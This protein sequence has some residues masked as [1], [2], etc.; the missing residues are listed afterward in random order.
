MGRTEYIA[1]L[2]LGTS[3]MLSIAARKDEK[4]VLT[5]LGAEKEMSG[6]CMCR[7]YIY[8]VDEAAQKVSA[9]VERLNK[10]LEAKVKKLYVGLGGQSIHAEYYTVRRE[11]NGAFVDDRIINSLYN[12]CMNYAPELMEI[13][14]IVSPEYYLDGRLEVDPQGLPCQIIEAKFLLILGHPSLK[15]N[16]E[17]SIEE[18]AKIEIAGFFISPLATA[19]AVLTRREKKLGCALVELGAG[20][21]YLSVYKNNLLRYLVAIP[22]GSNTITRD[23]IW[24]SGIPEEEAEGLKMSEGSVLIESENEEPLYKVIEARTNEIVAN[25]IEQIKVS[26]C[27]SSM[28]EGIII[29]GGG[30]QLRN[31]DEFIRL[32][33]NK[34]VRIACVNKSLVHWTDSWSD[35]IDDPANACAF[36]LL[37]LGKENCA[38]V[39]IPVPDPPVVEP[40]IMDPSG[41][42]NRRREKKGLREMWSHFS[43]GLFDEIREEE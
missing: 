28:G 5:I 17:K 4:G 33:T 12:G 39:V 23:I 27:E 40:I 34:P 15:T 1:A 11:M 36:G 42:T 37:A 16:L 2:D 41:N 21:T 38:K 26:G 22:L 13:L 32:K 8:H 6:A 43:K 25:I 18:K 35:L 24:A 29:T 9:L 19:E 3:K 31:L 14:E 7:G 30:S 10:K 20:I